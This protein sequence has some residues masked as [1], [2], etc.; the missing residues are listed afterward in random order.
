MRTAECPTRSQ[1]TSP[2]DD[3]RDARRAAEAALPAVAAPGAALRVETITS[4]AGMAA[5]EAEWDALARDV[6]PRTPF[7][8]ALW[9]R[10]WWRH[11]RESSATADDELRVLAFRD[12]QNRLIGVAPMMLTRRP[13]RL[14]LVRQLQFFGADPNVTEIRGAI[15]RP[16]D[17]A[18]V[19]EALQRQVQT[20]A[21]PWDWVLWSGPRPRSVESRPSAP[22][23]FFPDAPLEEFYLELPSSWASFKAPLSR[24]VKESIRKCYNSLQR[25]GWVPR[26]SV[27]TD[28]AQV[29][30]ALQGFF[31][32][33]A[34]RAGVTDGVPHP[35]VFA[36]PVPRQFLL[37][38]AQA[39]AGRDQLRIFQLWIG[40]RLV[41]TRVAFQFEQDLYLYYSGFARDWGRYSVM[42]TLFV[43]TVRWAIDQRLLR[44]HLSTGRDRS[45]LRWQPCVLVRP[46]GV[47]TRGHWISTVRYRLYGSI[48]AYMQQSGA[49]ARLLS[50]WRRN[51]QAGPGTTPCEE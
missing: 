10:T 36:D 32:L 14:P 39:M 51:R 5:L 44:M 38:Y 21:T 7:Q 18:R 40:D 31:E 4:E 17:R 15:C 43:E 23:R 3:A 50:P 48:R 13:G 8:T 16:R 24:N 12:E 34:D 2:L 45:K 11:F 9:N 37:D 22:F 26:F 1:L 47:L 49:W 25:D 46:R 6:L 30:E 29:D 35:N 33:H 27:V 28:T 42:T 41:A 20:D 19:M